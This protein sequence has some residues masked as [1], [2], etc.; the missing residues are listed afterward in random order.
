MMERKVQKKFIQETIRIAWP[1][2]LE[3]FFVSFASM[4]DSLM[5]SK[6]GASAVAAVGLT[7]QPKL[8]GF[9]FF[10]ALNVAISAL[11]ARRKGEKKQKEANYIFKAAFCIT[12][13][14]GILISIFNVALAEPIMHIAGSSADTHDSAVTYY[15]IIMGAMM[16]QIISLAI[17]AAQRGAGNT[18]IA[19][20]T[21][22][23]SSSINL[24]GNFFLINGPFGLPAFGIR[25]AAIATVMGTVVACVMS[26]RS[27]LKKDGF[28]SIY[29]I[30]ENKVKFTFSGVKQL[31]NI[32]VNTLIEQVL[33]RIG[34][35]IVAMMAA[36]MGTNEFA[37]HQVAMNVMAMSF[38][39]GDG[40]QIAAVTLIGQSLGQGNVEL[41]K[42]YGKICQYMGN[43]IS[44]IVS[45]CCLL[46]GRWYYGLF[47]K[48]Q[49][50]VAIG[51]II[52]RMLV[53]IVIFQ[54]SQV[55]YMGCLRGA[56]DVKFTT[57]AS[58]ISVTFVRTIAS[59]L[60]AYVA[61]FGVY[62]IWMGI[63]CD[64]ITRWL[65]TSLRF[66][67]GKWTSYRI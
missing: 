23:V 53:V 29:Y 49:E 36:R 39:L 51:V 5:V 55:I 62:G 13:V 19:L 34:F 30:I 56:G 57:I 33:M 11:T 14:A 45:L 28:I 64:Q 16:F 20:K 3:S 10:I 1:A 43:L 46:G 66:R 12:I 6:L 58:T 26:I 32:A 40:M 60:F 15:R 67:S 2:V 41:A 48:E 44:I 27:I 18:K 31:Y 25:G 38:S 9:C 37:A 24:I 50:I 61:G 4:L 54:I 63:I 17:N 21:N 47:F 65:F 52:M 35:I 42:K 59:Y 8:I 22:L 7:T